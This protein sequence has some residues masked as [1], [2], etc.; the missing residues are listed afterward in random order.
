MHLIKAII[1]KSEVHA[2]SYVNEHGTTVNRKEYQRRSLGPSDI[3]PPGTSVQVGSKRGTVI[4]HKVHQAHPSG[5][6]VVHT[7]QL[8]HKRKTLYGNVHKWEEL[9]KP[10]KWEGNYSFLEELKKSQMSLFDWKP[11]KH[12]E[13]RTV[14]ATTRHL[15]S[16]A[17]V[18][19]QEHQRKTMVSMDAMVHEARRWKGAA[20]N[21]DEDHGSDNKARLRHSRM[22]TKADLDNYLM[23]KFGIDESAAR[24]VSNHLTQNNVTADRSAEPHEFAGE[25]WA[26][27]V[28]NKRRTEAA[29]KPDHP[30]FD[31]YARAKQYVDNKKKVNRKYMQSEE[32]Q[33]M[34]PHLKEL[35]QKDR[36]AEK[37]QLAEYHRQGK[38]PDGRMVPKAGDKVFTA[39]AGMFGMSGSIQGEVY[40]AKSGLRVKVIKVNSMLGESVGKKDFALTPDWTVQGDPEL[41][42]RAKSR[43]E[44]EKAAEA[45]RLQERQEWRSKQASEYHQAINRGELSVKAN[46]VKEGDILNYYDGIGPGKKIEVRKVEEWNGGVYVSVSDPGPLDADG[47]LPG[48]FS[49]TLNLPDFDGGEMPRVT[50]DSKFQIPTMEVPKRKPKSK[51]EPRPASEYRIAKDDEPESGT[52]GRFL[53]TDKDMRYLE[54]PNEHG[55]IEVNWPTLLE[56]TRALNRHK[57]T[58]HTLKKTGV[59]GEYDVVPEQAKEIR[60]WAKQIKNAKDRD[61]KTDLYYQFLDS[62]HDPDDLVREMVLSLPPGY[63][64]FHGREYG[65]NIVD[66]IF[67]TYGTMPS[68]HLK[69]AHL[70]GLTATRPEKIQAGF[71]HDMDSVIIHKSC[72]HPVSLIKSK[73]TRNA[74][75]YTN[76]KGNTVVVPPSPLHHEY[77]T[78]HRHDVNEFLHETPIPTYIGNDGI[79]RHHKSK[80]NL[81]NAAEYEAAI[82]HVMGFLGNHA[83]HNH[84][85]PLVGKF[86]HHVVFHPNQESVNRTTDYKKAMIEYA[87]HSATQKDPANADWKILSTDKLQN[88]RHVKDIILRADGHEETEDGVLYWKIVREGKKPAAIAVLEMAKEGRDAIAGKLRYVTF[89]P[90]RKVP[91]NRTPNA[92]PDALGIVSAQ[93]VGE[94]SQTADL[95]KAIIARV[96]EE[97]NK[98]LA[99]GLY[100]IKAR[101]A[102]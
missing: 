79:Q 50:R 9:K 86:G 20:M 41:G 32:Y 45:K 57:Q 54:I 30:V 95:A 17:V 74:Y 7:V 36:D 8:T 6:V 99:N 92:N 24:D 47:Y 31:T 48:D 68:H 72:A 101:A 88:F 1:R 98:S 43:E 87:L 69:E 26:D 19:I 71:T 44:A 53:I 22:T 18:Q 90:T 23:R 3:L 83:Q 21:A 59:K 75:T 63:Y 56:A 96:T 10:E 29:D 4:K 73:D 52:K 5:T 14:H 62:G 16:G 13:Q 15:Q 38:Y 89:M 66:E 77:T 61:K 76:F 102:Q 46:E 34:Y 65:T 97:F 94:A 39:A 80:Y 58:D 55:E 33:K 60:Q 27:A 91:E 49:T 42:R 78:I 84:E 2:T 100:L 28:I 82:S 70:L 64:K 12:E 11:E 40:Q 51:P 93:T 85:A 35:Y 37:Q 67:K 81:K 25:P